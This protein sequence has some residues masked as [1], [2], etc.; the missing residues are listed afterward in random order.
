M[1]VTG[2]SERRYFPMTAPPGLPEHDPSYP[3]AFTAF[4]SFDDSA[5]GAFS[6]PVPQPGG[7]ALAG[8]LVPA[9]V[10]ADSLADMDS[11]I[12][13]LREGATT[14]V[15]VKRLAATPR[16]PDPIDYAASASGPDGDADELAPRRGRR[17]RRR[18]SVHDVEHRE[19]GPE[20]DRT[21]LRG[22]VAALA[23]KRS[24]LPTFE[25]PPRRLVIGAAA[26]GV[27]VIA[28]TMY[29][30]TTKDSGDVATALSNVTDTTAVDTAA[31]AGVDVTA[32]EEGVWGASADGTGAGAGGAATTI[33]T[34][35]IPP[36]TAPLPVTR[37]PATTLPA[38]LP[39]VSETIPEPVAPPTTS[40]RAA[41]APG[42]GGGAAAPATTT[43][44]ASPTTPP[45]H[46]ALLSG[47]TL[48][49]A[50]M[51]PSTEAAQ[52][53]I[54]KYEG[55]LGPDNV[56]DNYVIDA[57]A[58]ASK[59]GA[60]FIDAP[61]FAEGSS[62][63]GP[64]AG[65]SLGIGIAL[66]RLNPGARMTVLGYADPTSN[67]I[68]AAT[69]SKARA[70]AA[71]NYLVVAGGLDRRRFTAVGAGTVRPPGRVAPARSI[72]L[73]VIGLLG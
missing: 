4:D 29:L 53:F 2:T 54:A 33:V 38:Q 58:P 28:G 14:A 23:A 21:G 12:S 17:Q 16:G 10:P 30:S 49:L 26:L 7:P 44:A 47:G 48:D 22:R 69:L 6:D 32:A 19:F 15:N 45:T 3:P 66:L 72:D 34:A 64:T 50:G 55:A 73:R 37:R 39:V 59:D 41:A 9:T 1:D 63:L 24:S 70:D 25:R 11:D 8:G 60:V 27:L 51:L 61:L 67:A 56:T 68:A 20:P 40:G 71:V 5:F 46:R 31:D 57:S 62:T 13:R 65:D 35:T 18:Q 43:P 36:P 42:S 52:Q